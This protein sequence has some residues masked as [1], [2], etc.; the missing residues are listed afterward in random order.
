MP[1][2]L[3]TSAGCSFVRLSRASDCTNRPRRSCCRGI[4]EITIVYGVVGPRISNS[5]KVAWS[6][7]ESLIVDRLKT[8]ARLL[9]MVA[10]H[11]HGETITRSQAE[12]RAVRASYYSPAHGWFTLQNPARVI[13]RIFLWSGRSAVRFGTRRALGVRRGCLGSTGYANPNYR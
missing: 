12:G 13:T 6:I 1:R 8:S 10:I 9:G 5:R 7:D 4:T 11:S 2:N 3:S